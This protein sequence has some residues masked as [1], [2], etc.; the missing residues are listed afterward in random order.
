MTTLKK[1][2]DKIFM[3]LIY[4][5]VLIFILYPILSVFRQALF[6]DGVLSFRELQAFLQEDGYLL[7]NSIQVAAYTT[8]L[9]TV[10]SVSTG[11]FYLM[12]GKRPRMIINGIMLLTMISPPFV[13]AL[14]YISLFGRR[15]FITHNILGLTLNTYGMWGIILMQSLGFISLNCLVITGSLARLNPQIIHSARDLGADTNSVIRD[16]V[17]PMLRPTILIVALLTFVR[18]LSDFGTPTIIGGN[19]NTLATEAYMSMIAYGD[20]TRAATINI[21]LFVPALLVFFVYRKNL[22]NTNM[23]GSGVLEENMLRKRGGLFHAARILAIT[24]IVMI[25]L[26]YGA[27]LL[28]AFTKKRAGDPYFTLQNFIDTQPYIT[29]TFA[30]SIVYS[31]I[32]GIVGALLGLLIGYYLEIR[33]LRFMGLIDL[34]ATL[35][36]IIPGSFFGIGY[37]L[38]FRGPPLILTGTAAIVVLNVLFKQLPFSSK[39]GI[40]AASQINKETINSV[41]DLGGSD[42]DVLKD[43]VVPV[44]RN[45]LFISFANNFTATMTTVGSII[46]LVYP[47]QKLAT[48]VMF[49][50]IQ[51]GKYGVGSVIALLIILITLSINLLFYKFLLRRDPHVSGSNKPQEA[52]PSYPS[53]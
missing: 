5:S 24:F 44:S 6:A 50:V 42:M 36:Y 26:Q 53:R 4:G 10:I 27:I 43:V 8:I 1:V 47:G 3:V 29:G 32:A 14:S 22:K 46:F 9:S 12:S 18:S 28:T 37:I 21:V 25:L 40:D 7:K 2:L 51:S 39:I 35:P 15:G 49:D 48:L 13:T 30:R 52:L 23:T 19:F 38:A 11:I 20:I 41:K 33:K 34:I 16:V 17:L 31:L 45:S